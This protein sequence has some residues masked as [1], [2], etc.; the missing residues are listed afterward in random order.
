VGLGAVSGD[1]PVPA[2]YDGDGRTDEAIYRNGIWYIL[3]SSDGV[4][5]SVGLGAAF[6]DVPV[7]ADYDGDGK[8]DQA[9]YRNGLWFI[10]QS[11]NGVLNTVG[12]GTT[13]DVPLN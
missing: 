7:Q 9:V 1:V 11:S 10:R 5:T 2:D 12:L 6:G 8:A 4:L 13:G 3:R